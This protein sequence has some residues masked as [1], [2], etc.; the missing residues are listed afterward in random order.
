MNGNA[1]TLRTAW[2]WRLGT[3]RLFV[4]WR[5]GKMEKKAQYTIWN[6]RWRLW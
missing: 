2:G 6:S 1:E 4:R 3:Q 5:R